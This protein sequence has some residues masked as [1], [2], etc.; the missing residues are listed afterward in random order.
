[1]WV[2]WGGVEVRHNMSRKVKRNLCT[3]PSE[4]IVG[5]DFDQTHCLFV[6]I[7]EVLRSWGVDRSDNDMQQGANNVR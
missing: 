4:T 3:F 5:D 2:G 1:M 7:S 6:I